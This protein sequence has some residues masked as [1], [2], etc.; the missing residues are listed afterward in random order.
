MDDFEIS[1]SK[2]KGADYYHLENVIK[3]KVYISL[4][5]SGLI[6]KFNISNEMLS[7]KE[8]WLTDYTVNLDL[9]PQL[10]KVF[11]DGLRKLSNFLE[12][13]IRVYHVDLPEVKEEK[14]RID[15]LVK[16]YEK[17]G[18]FS[19]SRA[20]A[21][22]LGYFK[23][24]AVCEIIDNEKRKKQVRIPRV[25]T[26]LDQKTYYVV[27]KMREIPFLRIKMPDCVYDY[28]K[29]INTEELERHEE[30]A[31]EV[32]YNILKEEFKF[33]EAL[34]DDRHFKC[35]V[36]M[37]IGEKNTIENTN[38]ISVFEDLI[39]PCVEH[40]GYNIECYHAGLIGE[41]GSI[42]EQIINALY[43]D[44]IVIAD[45]R[46]QN[47]NVIWELGIRHSFLRRLTLPLTLYS[48]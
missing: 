9:E 36:I 28:E 26:D 40:C 29:H 41:A 18:S 31:V 20:S 24:A 43:N 8:D 34:K 47:P 32:K 15:V 27:A 11:Y 37:P 2:H 1:L 25:L 16:Y 4:G 7:E 6:P 13:L 5:Q 33:G 46:R 42:P 30:E 23:A 10:Y 17:K 48:S 19:E 44:D 39:K 3:F 35:F 22:T 14:E 12:Q 38:N 45:L 21:D